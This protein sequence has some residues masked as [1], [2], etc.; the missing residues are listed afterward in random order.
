MPDKDLSVVPPV[1]C[2]GPSAGT[3]HHLVLMIDREHNGRL[4]L[5]S[6]T[7]LS[8]LIRAAA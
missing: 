1:S 4:A 7:S 6:G 3:I 5:P 2:G 8:N